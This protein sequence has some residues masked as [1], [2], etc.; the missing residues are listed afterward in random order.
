MSIQSYEDVYGYLKKKKGNSFCRLFGNTNQ[1]WFELKFKESLL[2]YKKRRADQKYKYKID[3]KNITNYIPTVN[4]EDLNLCDWTHGFQLVCQKKTYVL[5]SQTQEEFDKWGRAFCFILGKKTYD[6]NNNFK[7]KKQELKQPFLNK[8]SIDQLNQAR[9]EQSSQSNQSKTVIQIEDKEDEIK[10]E[11]KGILKNK[12][13]KNNIAID[14]DQEEEED[15]DEEEEDNEGEDDEEEE[16]E[17][18]KTNKMEEEN[19]NMTERETSN[20][21]NNKKI[22]VADKLIREM[23]QKGSFGII[24]EEKNSGQLNKDEENETESKKVNESKEESEEEDNEEEEEDEENEE[25]EEKKSIKKQNI[26]IPKK[27]IPLLNIAKIKNEEQ[28]KNQLKNNTVLDLKK[29]Q[30]EMKKLKQELDTKTKQIK[31]HDIDSLKIQKEEKKLPEKTYT[32]PIKHDSKTKIP[33]S[34]KEE[35]IEEKEEEAEEEEEE[36]EEEEKEGTNKND[37]LSQKKEEIKKK[38]IDP[39][40]DYPI[41]TLKKENPNIFEIENTNTPKIPTKERV[42]NIEPNETKLNTSNIYSSTN[43]EQAMS[44][45]IDDSP[46]NQS[47]NNDNDEPE[48]YNTHSMNLTNNSRLSNSFINCNNDD[49]DDW[50]FYDESNNRI[51]ENDLKNFNPLNYNPE[52]KGLIDKIHKNKNKVKLIEEVLIEPNAE[53]KISGNHPI[54]NSSTKQ[55][56]DGINIKQ[57]N[58]QLNYTNE[59]IQPD[60]PV[61]VEIMPVTLIE[62]DPKDTIPQMSINKNENY[63]YVPFNQREVIQTNVVKVSKRELKNSIQKELE[64]SKK[65]QKQTGLYHKPK[66][67]EIK[68][69]NYNFPKNDNIDTENYKTACFSLGNEMVDESNQMP[70]INQ[71]NDKPVKMYTNIDQP[72]ITPT[73]TTQIDKRS[74]IYKNLVTDIEKINEEFSNENYLGTYYRKPNTSA[75]MYSKQSPNN[76]FSSMSSNVIDNK[77]LSVNNVGENRSSTNSISF[78]KVN[79]DFNYSFQS[80][81]IEDSIDVSNQNLN[82]EILEKPYSNNENMDSWEEDNKNNNSFEGSYDLPQNLYRKKRIKKKKEE[83]KKKLQIENNTNHVKIDPPKVE[84]KS[85]IEDFEKWEI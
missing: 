15:G 78:D 75:L 83:E 35:K 52:T 17:E 32:I 66:P 63:M 24:E 18:S 38:E 46:S 29:E 59:E 16:E 64:E 37:K 50:N 71:K 6:N 56:T 11:K 27:D 4:N 7:K 62:K 80:K 39:N 34:S 8:N 84:T 33:I 79:I 69:N 21:Q 31:E 45:I 57:S 51:A 73:P 30:E 44:Q 54:T 72:N 19:G 3:I 1:R 61:S 43:I 67:V 22:I 49:F 12:N 47:E 65:S 82:N 2:G 68:K 5:Y 20:K 70:S 9:R 26:E 53:L 13:E 76:T 58:N 42:Y 10:Q 28:N 25:E 23:A 41:S 85:A 48:Y 60:N 14:D 40:K 55:D 81:N 74:N 36:E 77:N